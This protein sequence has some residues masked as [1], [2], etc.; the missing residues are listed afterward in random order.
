MNASHVKQI[1]LESAHSVAIQ[2]GAEV[3]YGLATSA[4]VRRRSCDD[5][6]EG[7]P[8]AELAVQRNRQLGSLVQTA[9]CGQCSESGSV[10]CGELG[11]ND[12]AKQ[13]AAKAC[14]TFRRLRRGAVLS[15]QHGEPPDAVPRIFVAVGDGSGRWNRVEGRALQSR[16][17]PDLQS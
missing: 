6:A 14:L 17:I 11:V 4:P 13:R 7:R 15:S 2:G 1:T 16:C 10:P 8:R 9:I 12:D 5:L 3:G